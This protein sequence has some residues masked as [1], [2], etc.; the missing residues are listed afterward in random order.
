MT[1]LRQSVLLLAAAGMVA[2]AGCS[3]EKDESSAT[4]AQVDKMPAAGNIA[5]TLKSSDDTRTIGDALATTGLRTVFDDKASYTLLAPR[6]A[7]FTALGDKGKALTGAEDRTAMAALVRD[8]LIPGYL[9]PKDIAAA[10]AANDSGTVKMR[11]LGG[12]ELTFT[13][14]GND[15]EVASAD[16]SKAVLATE[17]IT[18]GHSVA[19]PV[20]SVLKAL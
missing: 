9:T 13:K 8:H 6:D 11:T 7:A 16:G 17:P 12:T 2:L 14:S 20:D 3:S 10:I 5:D 1:Q 18:K 15:I 4:A 19:I